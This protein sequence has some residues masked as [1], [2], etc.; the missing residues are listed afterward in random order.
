MRTTV[1]FDADTAKAVERLRAE[2]GKGVS[3]AVNELIRRGMRDEPS[4]PP[5]V[6]RSFDL[7]LTI[8][9][10]NVADALDLL[11]GPDAR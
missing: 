2:H 7:G 4:P 1:E 6:P 5:F 9:V 8:D 3:E 10:S 11:E